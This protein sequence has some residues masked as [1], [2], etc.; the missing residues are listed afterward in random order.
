M[1]TNNIGLKSK[2]FFAKFTSI[3]S[4]SANKLFKR[5]M[6][7]GGKKSP[8]KVSGL[9]GRFVFLRRFKIK[10]RLI[11]S[12]VLLLIAVISVTG[13][14]SYNSS[15]ETIDD[16]V[17]RYSLQVMDQTG[18]VL[19]NKINRMEE[20][21]NDIGL[22][23]NIQNAVLKYNT[24]SAFDQYEQVKIIT[25][26]LMTK[27]VDADDVDYCAIIHGEDF[28]QVQVFNRGQAE[29]DEEK[30]AKTDAQRLQWSYMDFVQSGKTVSYYGIL[31]NVKGVTSGGVIA[32]MVLIP[33]T[34]YLASGFEGLDIGKDQETNKIFPVFVVDSEGT[35][36]AS[37][38]TESYA[39]DSSNDNSKL[40]AGEIKKIAAAD[41]KNKSGNLDISVSDADSLVTYSRIGNKDWYVVSVIPYEY[42]NSAA[43]EL[44][45]KIIFI[46]F[47]CIIA[48]FL[49]CLFIA[50][51]VSKPLS[52][53]VAIM[54]KA[55]MGDLTNHVKDNGKDEIA[56][57]CNNYNDMIS[58]ICLLIQKVKESSLHV[59]SSADK[60]ATASEQTYSVSEQVSQSIQEMAMGSTDQASEINDS[61]ADISKL[62]EGIA[63]VEENV[64]KVIS[65]ASR[66]SGLN[67]N[68]ASTINELNL[69]SAQVSDTTNKVY[70]NIN[71]LSNSMKEIQKILKMQNTISEQTNLLALNA[72][73][74]AARAGDAGKGF[75]VVAS[76]VS[77]LAEKSKEFNRVI[78]GIISS[79]GHKTDDTVGEVLK[80]NEVVNEQ[81]NAVKGTEKLFDTVFGSME[82]VLANIGITEK[83]VADIMK[84][85]D[86]VLESIENISAVAQESAAATEQ[87][88]ASTQEQITAAEELSNQAKDL[89]ELAEALNTEIT[90]FRI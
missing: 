21:I 80:S 22:D 50:R 10:T 48:A 72:S 90:K 86:N 56:D 11:A 29:L 59:F 25:E 89:K 16:K 60:I 84:S 5:K 42:L 49:L 23:R 55:K 63:F 46:G 62:S 28:S 58:N 27:F 30:A 71:D 45:T 61:V 7:D 18:V 82:E 57:V 43:N 1:N 52:K 37:R 40:I 34:N 66:I 67:E 9:S 81:I 51:S 19:E 88:T 36:L 73:I 78:N 35:I 74:E 20:Y 54:K 2:S 69:K 38:N 24:G 32:K 6:I 77:K 47:I 44:R 14:F 68:A 39:V 8:D 33:K 75:A 41:S 64:A 70:T 53:L 17:K 26:Y 4:S 13:I 31:Q 3:F 15:T 79:I 83:S 65:I 87:I 85:K 12:F 76:E